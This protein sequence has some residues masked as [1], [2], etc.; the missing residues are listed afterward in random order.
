MARYI[1]ADKFTER[2]KLSPAFKN[3]AFEGDLL[4]RVVLD[5]LDNA[6]TADVV[7]VKDARW[8]GEGMGGYYCSLCQEIVS[9]NEFKYCPY[10][11]AKMDGGKI[12]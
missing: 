6:P 4:Q 11:G 7:E 5:L 8:K 2:I 1:D 12:K 3:M 10:C 9:G